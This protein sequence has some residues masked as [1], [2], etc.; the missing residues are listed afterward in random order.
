MVRAAGT[1]WLGINQWDNFSSTDSMNIRVEDTVPKLLLDFLKRCYRFV[2]QEW[3]HA[4]REPLPDQGFEQRFRESCVT[5]LQEWRISQ[6]REMHLGDGLDTASGVLHEVDIVARHS[7]ITVILEIKNRQGNP[8]EKND[9]I[10]FFAKILDYLTSNPILLL[11]EVCPVFMSNTSFQASGLAA[12]LG[13]GIH[14][15]APGLRPLSI[16]VDNARRIDFEIKKGIVIDPTMCEKFQ[17]F[18]VRLNNISSQL[19][20]TWMTNRFGYQSED[21]IVIKSVGGLPTIALSQE[22]RQLNSDCTQLL[23]NIRIAKSKAKV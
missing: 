8:P 6:E 5:N 2:D 15:V 12:C 10:V 19:S 23:D 21:R 3:Q 7:D 22:L 14:A 9:I 20:E 11:K 1:E 13:L 4:I 16:L 18:C 17:D